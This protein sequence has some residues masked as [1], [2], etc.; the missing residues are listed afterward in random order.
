[1]KATGNI[2]IDGIVE[3]AEISAGKDIVLR[4]GMMG[5]QKARVEARGSI[6]AQ[7]FEYTTIQAGKNIEADVLM[8]CEVTCGERVTLTGN[9][10]SIVGGY[11]RAVQGLEAVEIGNDAEIQTDVCVGVSEETLRR[12]N[13]LMKKIE[14]TRE[15]LEHTEQSLADF[16]SLRMEQGGD[17][18]KEDPRRLQLFRIKIQ[19]SAML[20]KDEEE[21]ADLQETIEKAKDATIKVFGTIYPGVMVLESFS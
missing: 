17:S 15:N 14:A 3:A 10:G 21:I 2:T 6:Y 4:S 7:F 16:E 20:A 18:Y 19:D 12:A 5:G 13:L 8:E 11:V 1:M 9:H